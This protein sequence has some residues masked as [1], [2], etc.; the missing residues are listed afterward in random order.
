M[1]NLFSPLIGI[2]KALYL[3]AYD[4][5][6]NYGLALVLLSLF[7]FVVLYP[8]N[9][10]AQ[11]IQN[12]EHKI[13][14]VLTPQI[15][16]IKKQYS[17]QEQYEQLQWLYQRYGYHPLYAIRSALGFILQ[18]PFLTA[19]YYML[20]G[21]AEI[22][23][24]PWGI[25]PDL[26]SPDYLLDGINVLPFVMTL[27]TVVYAFVMP[28][29]SQ[30]ERL[31]T[32]GIGVFFLILLY[33]APSALLIFWICN[34]IWSLLDC[35][36]SKRLEWLGDYIAENELAFHIIFALSLTVGLLVPSEIYIKNASQL[37]FS[38]ADILKYFFAD[39]AKY[40]GVLLFVYVICRRRI[41]KYTYL[42]MLLGILLGVFLQSYVIELNY[43]VFDGHEIEWD[44]Y[45][46]LG[47]VN[48]FIWLFCI[49]ET[50]VVFRRLQFDS[51]RITRFVKPIAFCI[52]VIQCTVLLLT[53]TKNPIYKDIAYKEGGMGIL[54]T[55][56]M[57]TISTKKNIIVFLLDA[58]DASVFEEIQEKNPEVLEVFKDFSFYPDTTS[59]F[60]FTHYSL[61]EI[62]TGI[63]YNPQTRYSEYLAKAWKQTPYYQFLKDED[64]S[65]CLY[66]SGNYVDKKAP[67]DN[68]V[69]EKVRVDQ[70]AADSID[71]IVKFRILPHYLKK[72]YYYYD[73][74][75]LNPISKVKSYKTDDRS[76]YMGLKGGLSKTDKKAFRFYYLNG[77]H[78]PCVYDEN[79]EIIDGKSS[80]SYRQ[81]IG[82]LKI[83][84]EYIKQMKQY[85]L[86]DG[87]A[88]AVIADHGFHNTI[89]SR[90]LFLLKY[91]KMK[92]Q[93]LSIDNKSLS[94]SQVM[95]F[96]IN[97]DAES[98]GA[99]IVNNKGND[100]FYYYEAEGNTKFI[101]YQILQPAKNI[102]SWLLMGELKKISI[103][104]RTYKLG[105]A[106]DFSCFGDAG[107][108]KTF[109]WRAREEEYGTVMAKQEAELVLDIVDLD[110]YK[111]EIFKIN[112][113][114][115]VWPEQ[116]K[117]S[118]KLVKLFVNKIPTVQWRISKDLVERVQYQTI[119]RS[120]LKQKRLHLI[121]K[122]E[123][124][125]EFDTNNEEFFILKKLY[126]SG[127]TR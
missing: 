56:N 103:I 53:L 33:S 44:N 87:A 29:I 115:L 15:A 95:S 90:P 74:D 97:K 24:V 116:L 7:T 111:D 106:I 16:D 73:P 27:V 88:C 42:S 118:H 117:S 9:K 1:Y 70:K 61:P 85:D 19:A 55:D 66:T 59:S 47:I 25:I 18:I 114:F 96:L 119:S 121:F 123:N 67:I 14:A 86:F 68:L 84:G 102:E 13:Q 108:Y 69:F 48:S 41:I 99:F 6:G 22:Q 122:I 30:K 46:T 32:I 100:R 54:T 125:N 79:M 126:I 17:G 43:G 112:V 107:K 49:V 51:H 77:I 50:F 65:I 83:V 105:D 3:F 110:N 78:P 5:T 104:D 36:L 52:V 71:K 60:G 39:T 34:L 35:V 81:A 80:N 98:P 72:R 62:L 23:G 92:G 11:Q 58:F 10:K 113:D 64:F 20:S 94:I 127:N 31:Q 109:G 4:F 12:K 124:I 75:V 93:K 91:P 38:F 82:E 8:F 101:K 63:L 120:I 45:T 37:W 21:L 76:F 28:E 2:Y 40:F 26:S 89:G 57:Y